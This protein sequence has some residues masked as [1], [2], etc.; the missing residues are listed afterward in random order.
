M[1]SKA[2][3]VPKEQIN[4]IVN[5]KDLPISHELS[6][7]VVS[8]LPIFDQEKFDP[9]VEQINLYRSVQEALET[10][11]AHSEP[12]MKIVTSL[13]TQQAQILKSLTPY[14]YSKVEIFQVEET[15]KP[16]INITL[17]GQDLE[18]SEK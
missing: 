2:P 12:D 15:K 4:D 6:W 8:P 1:P 7:N 16:V 18:I 13:L 5:P 3:L 9:L 11:R 14:R 10:E 17:T